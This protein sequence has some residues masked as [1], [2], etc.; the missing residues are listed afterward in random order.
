MK[1]T[2]KRRLA[3]NLVANAV[4]KVWVMLVQLISVPV[5][6]AK[7]GANGYGLWLMLTTIPSYIAL[8]SFGFGTAA[9][10]GMTQQWAAGDRDG[11]L[12]TFQSVWAL[13]SMILLFVMLLAVGIWIFGYELLPLSRD[14]VDAGFALVFYSVA[15]VQMSLVAAGYQS[16]GRYAQG[17]FLY[18]LIGPAETAALLGAALLGGGMTAVAASMTAV[19]IVGTLAY[20]LWL[21]TRE[22]WI[23]LGFAHASWGEVKRLAN[24]AVASLSMTLS[25][26]LSLQ[27]L[28]LTLGLFVSPAATAAFA[29]TRLLTRVP[30]QF[31]ALMSRASLP[32]MTAAHTRGDR[33]IVASLALVSLL[34][35]AIVV[36]PSTIVFIAYGPVA[37]TLLSKGELHADAS[38]FFWLALTAA[39]QACWTTVGQFLF[40]LN[41]QQKFAYHY[42]LLAALAA[43]SPVFVG[44]TSDL[45]GVAAVW[46]AAEFA[47]LLVVYRAWW[48]ENHLTS[49]DFLQGLKRIST[50]VGISRT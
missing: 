43:A 14:A 42:I 3:A 50:H 21:R 11:A 37:L 48:H 8:S 35:T 32:E 25:S 39:F 24:P 31:T 28:T 9:A 16:T 2:L 41:K 15:A 46:C 1:S 26:A 4:G 27:G 29:T 18:D 40:A 34:S 49:L 38:L 36:V 47:M 5:L 12:R 22:P 45:A 19:R 30:L 7:W 6:T 44:S 17:T 13:I 33:P 10:T 23:K 20:Y